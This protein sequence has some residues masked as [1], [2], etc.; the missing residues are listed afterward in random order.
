MIYGT[1]NLENMLPPIIELFKKRKIQLLI[2]ILL[3]SLVYMNIFQN[4]FVMDDT[5]FIV[6]WDEIKNLDNIRSFFK[7][8]VPE[9]HEGIYRPLK[10][11][12][13]MLSYKLW[14]LNPAGY[15]LQ[16]ILVHLACTIL[17]YFISLRITNKSDIAFMTS[18]LFG[19]HPIHTESITFI[20]AS[21]DILGF[22]FFFI[23]FYLYLKAE[24]NY[25]TSVIFALLAFF[26]YELTLMLPL[27]IFLYDMCFKKIERK[28]LTK[29]LKI[30]SYY[31]GG[32]LSYLLIR[33]SVL[34][35]SKRGD[36]LAGSFYST[37]LTMTKV[38]L[39]YILLIMAPVNLNINHTV[40]KGIL[41]Y[42]T[43]ILDKAVI[44]QS[45]TDAHILVSLIVIVCLLIVAI[46]SFK[47]Y[48]VI[49]F[50]VG[51][52]FIGLSPVLNVI[53]QWVIL[54]ER[55]LYLSSFG[56]CLLLSFIIYKS[57][58]WLLKK[59]KIKHL[60]I[61]IIMFFVFIVIFYSL[62][63]F[64]RNKDWKDDTSIRLK[65]I[66]QSP[67]SHVLHYDLGAA[68]YE[69]GKTSL[70]IEQYLQSLKINPNFEKARYNLGLAY[71]D[72]GKTDLAIEEYKKAIEINP[73]YI[74]AHYALGILYADQEKTD[75]AIEEY[76][77]VLSINPNH[78]A[79]HN[80]LGIIYSI[81]G[82]LDLAIQEYQE[83]TKADPKLEEARYNLN[84]ALALKEAA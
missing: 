79:A 27:L 53:P 20:T 68:Y 69:Q 70:A 41:S 28:N 43:E 15:H 5:H 63:A 21:F 33:F 59:D 47:K 9:G 13:L 76:Q 19:V 77:K 32:V 35:I 17:V 75:L 73:G 39:K 26:T 83:A 18:L 31:F 52:F 6:N 11:V 72:Q 51:M 74:K 66:E 57:Y 16:S 24:H 25:L 50:C 48:P 12:F 30:Y 10:S 40:S 22:V 8:D 1:L 55:Y 49:S 84:K 56:F 29:K 46:K 34:H 71:E 78:A 67:D 36:Y 58:C 54:A 38:L 23:A 14:G 7:G 80:N 44:A 82:K 45:I 37:M 62:S 3:T 60:R 4:R 61:G 2:I 65:A 42:K 64:S 81:Q